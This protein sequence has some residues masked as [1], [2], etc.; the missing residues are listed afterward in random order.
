MVSPALADGGRQGLNSIA[1]TQRWELLD[2]ATTSHD[3]LLLGYRLA[4]ST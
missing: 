1:G 4:D 2:S 3:R